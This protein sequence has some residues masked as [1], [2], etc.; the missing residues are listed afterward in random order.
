MS[1]WKACINSTCLVTVTCF[2]FYLT[3]TLLWCA[4]NTF[5]SHIIP[6]AN[7]HCCQ[8]PFL[9]TIA[10][11]VVLEIPS[12]ISCQWFCYQFI[13]LSL[14]PTSW[15]FKIISR[16]YDRSW[17][18]THNA[19]PPPRFPIRSAMSDAILLRG[20]ICQSPIPMV[21]PL[22][23][24]GGALLRKPRTFGRLLPLPAGCILYA[25][26]SRILEWTYGRVWHFMTCPISLSGWQE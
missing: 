3:V 22:H 18:M 20:P 2:S 15:N 8:G 4:Y 16:C 23:C 9:T 25:R 1:V 14:P 10:R 21:T 17:L 13:T 12:S 11:I 5:T 19:S 6:H 26:K 7:R 24:L